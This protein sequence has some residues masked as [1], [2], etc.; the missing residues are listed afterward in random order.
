[1]RLLKPVVDTLIGLLLVFDVVI[2][3]QAYQHG[4]PKDVRMTEIRPGV[5]GVTV[6]R[7]PLTAEDGLIFALLIGLHLLL[8]Y[9]AWRFRR[10]RST[11]D[12]G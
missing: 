6:V 2:G 11:T 1:M 9:L 5:E 8:I 10:Q 3:F 12:V 7:H 4:W